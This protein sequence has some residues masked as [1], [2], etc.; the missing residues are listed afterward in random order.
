MSFPSDLEIARGVTPRPIAGTEGARDP[1]GPGSA[2]MPYLP[3]ENDGQVVG[4]S[5]EG[6]GSL[7]QADV[8][9]GAEPTRKP[10]GGA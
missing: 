6:Q 9:P 7:T 4:G 5:N 10:E 1:Y 2:P 8:T 3:G